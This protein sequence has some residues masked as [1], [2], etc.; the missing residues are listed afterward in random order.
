[1]ENKK[2][3]PNVLE[4]AK[5]VLQDRKFRDNLLMTDSNMS[6]PNQLNLKFGL[7]ADELSAICAFASRLNTDENA[8]LA[9]QMGMMGSFS[10][11]SSDFWTAM[12]AGNPGELVE[13][14]IKK[15][16]IVLEN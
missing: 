7:S 11:R 3:S 8:K 12:R 6:Y 13:D 10:K 1:M 4:A 16:G 14:I 15:L 2:I 9:Q 5:F